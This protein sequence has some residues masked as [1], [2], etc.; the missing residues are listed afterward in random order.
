MNNRTL[1]LL[2]FAGYFGACHIE[3]SSMGKASN[4]PTGN[5]DEPHKLALLVGIGRYYQL[6]AHPGQRP[7]PILHVRDETEEYR[8]VLM[9]DYGFLDGDVRVLLD[10]QATAAKIRAAFKEHLINRARPGDVVLFH[11]SGHGQQIPDDNDPVRRDEA[12]GL[13]ES[14]VPYD[15]VDQSVAEGVAKNIR[16]DEVNEWLEALAAQISAVGHPGLVDG[17]ITVTL[18]TCFSGSATRGGLVARGRPWDTTIDGPL[19]A[20]RPLLPAEAAVGLLP[21]LGSSRHNV[22]VLAAARGDQSAWEN[23]GRGVF[24]KHWVRLLASVQA[25]ALPT[26]AAA[27]DKLAIDIAAEGVDQVPQV[28]GAADH[29]LFSGRAV[30]FARPRGGVR[31]LRDNIGQWWLQSGDVQGITVG[32]RYQLYEAGAPSLNVTARI[33]EA[34]V[35]EVQPF[36]ARL[37]PL[38]MA[39]ASDRRGALAI[40]TSHA[41]ARA[42]LH[43]LLTGFVSA[44]HLKKTLAGLD[45]LRIADA[46]PNDE[47]ESRSYDLLLRYHASANSVDILR[48]ASSLPVK[49]ISLVHEGP[50]GLEGWLQ[51]EWRRRQLIQLQHSNEAARIDLELIPLDAQRGSNR[52]VI[53]QPLVLPTPPAAAHIALS[54][55]KAF[56]LRL[57]NRSSRALYAAVLAMSQDGGIDLLYPRPTEGGGS[58]L[59][60]GQRLE[61][62]LSSDVVWLVGEPGQRVILKVI[63]SDVFVDL[64]GIITQS[65]GTPS[66][67]Q[68]NLTYHPLQRLLEGLLGGTRSGAMNVEPAE[69]GTTDASVTILP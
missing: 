4:S 22:V 47:P 32:S 10:E 28:E 34:T 45:I 15:A 14:L 44:P 63:A 37:E 31:V 27:I 30:P 69:W 33:A 61:P 48:P 55:G 65:R 9:R 39:G 7:W 49:T 26:Y 17:H 50:I 20:P 67:S 54:R 24:S 38:P 11:Y 2:S 5:G 8:Q 6:A 53:G 52:Q 56:A 66:P 23:R 3:N 25:S 40:E 57:I 58:Q 46:D 68:S 13:D 62:P 12:D 59:A 29:A 35:V 16:D 1:L 43:A 41:Y 19:P 21:A 18:D 36:R 60:P 64:T 51:A 42:P